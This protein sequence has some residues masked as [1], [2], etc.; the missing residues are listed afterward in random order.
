MWIKKILIIVI[1]IG[2]VLIV[3]FNSLDK[4]FMNF[5]N[6]RHIPNKIA[7]TYVKTTSA[8]TGYGSITA[9]S[10][11]V[12]RLQKE[13]YKVVAVNKSDLSI[14]YALTNKSKNNSIRIY[15]DWSDYSLF[16]VSSSYMDSFDLVEYMR[17]K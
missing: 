10:N 7:K 17:G 8:T 13:G 16:W 9:L 4:S 14:D 3:K 6:E 12:L 11:L 2:F 1:T 15:Y 5:S